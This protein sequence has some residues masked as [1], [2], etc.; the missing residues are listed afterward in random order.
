MCFQETK[1]DRTNSA[2]VKS[3]WG[4]SFLDWMALD[5][6][7]TAGCILVVWGIRVYE[8]ID[9]VVGSFSASVLLKGVADGFVWI[10]MGVYG[11]NDAGLRDTFWAE[12]DS[13]RVRWN[14]AWCVLG[15]FNIIRYP[16]ERLGCNSFS[17]AMFN[18]SDFSERNFLI[19]LPLVGCEYT[20]YRDSANS[21]MSRIDR[22]L[23]STDW[24]EHF[25]N[26]IQRPLPR[27]VSDHCPILVEAK[28]WRGEKV[29]LNLRTCG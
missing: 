17:P 16:A 5:A 12:L 8:K 14:S 10:C 19:D 6:I 9:C 26:V 15:D 2:A 13:V 22:V 4:S 28:A 1:L 11:P 24:E 27:V 7:H 20:W 23:V 21:A 29:P 25:L 18:F 3:L